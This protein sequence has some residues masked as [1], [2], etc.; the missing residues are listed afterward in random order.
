MQV[1]RGEIEHAIREAVGVSAALEVRENE[2]VLTG[3]VSTERER[4]A[5]LEVTAELAPEADIIDE[6]VVSGVLPDEL[7]GLD[8]SEGDIG[9]FTGSTPGTSD[10]E[11]LEPGDFSDQDILT[12]PMGGSGPSGTQDELDADIAEGE[13]SVMPP[14]DPPRD[15]EGEF[16]GGFQTSAMDDK[17]LVRSE[18]V[19]GPADE[20]L[21]EAVRQE[22]LQDAATTALQID[23]QVTDGIVTL[24][25]IVDDLLDA[26]NAADVASR[27]PGV[28]E[29]H[30]ELE[31]RSL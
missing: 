8:L 11:A 6:L 31:V 9:G 30:D 27:V 21:A 4:D 16:L 17:E 7:A 12:N 15:R 19:P 2:V 14:I 13:E 28:L 20:G 29:V 3:M 22:L 18:I 5:V 1:D 26:D 23:V 24:R 10:A 25:G